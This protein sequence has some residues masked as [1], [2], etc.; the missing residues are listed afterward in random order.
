M[1][2]GQCDGRAILFSGCE[3]TLHGGLPENCIGIRL[4]YIGLGFVQPYVF[5]CR[6]AWG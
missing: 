1:L 2:I 6:I 3:K 5:L 4:T